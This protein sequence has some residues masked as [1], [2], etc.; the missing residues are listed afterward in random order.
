MHATNYKSSDES[1]NLQ[2]YMH[3]YFLILWVAEQLSNVDIFYEMSIG[4]LSIRLNSKNHFI[5]KG[6]DFSLK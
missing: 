5:R 4:S 1:S 2:V 3:T 6:N